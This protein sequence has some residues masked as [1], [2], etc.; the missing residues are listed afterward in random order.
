MRWCDKKL[1][2]GD[3]DGDDV[4]GVRGKMIGDDRGGD[5]DKCYATIGKSR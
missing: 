4:N 2:S 3:D 1:K 5:A